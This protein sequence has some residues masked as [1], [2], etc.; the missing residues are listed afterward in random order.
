MDLKIDSSSIGRNLNGFYQFLIEKNYYQTFFGNILNSNKIED[1][2][3]Y[4]I[5]QFY[6]IDIDRLKFLSE[7]QINCLINL[8]IKR[9]LIGGI[10]KN[11][12]FII[13]TFLIKSIPYGNGELMEDEM[14]FRNW[15]TVLFEKF[16]FEENVEILNILLSIL[17]S[18][19]ESHDVNFLRTIL[20]NSDRHETGKS[21]LKKFE[22]FWIKNLNE[23]HFV[24][25]R[26]GE[27]FQM[28]TKIIYQQFEVEEMN[29]LKM[30][31]SFHLCGINLMEKKGDFEEIIK[32]HCRLPIIMNST[33][34]SNII[35]NRSIY[36]LL[37]YPIN[38]LEKW[39]KCGED[40]NVYQIIFY[41]CAVIKEI[42]V[43]ANWEM[44]IKKNDNYLYF[45]NQIKQT[46]NML[47]DN[48]FTILQSNDNPNELFVSRFLLCISQLLIK[49]PKHFMD[50]SN[51]SQYFHFIFHFI[52]KLSQNQ[53]KKFFDNLLSIDE[54]SCEEIEIQFQNYKYHILHHFSQ[55]ILFDNYSQFN[56][57]LFLRLFE[58]DKFTEK[59]K[60]IHK[61]IN[62]I[63]LKLFL[64]LKNGHQ[65]Q[66]KKII[67][68]YK[69]TFFH[70]IFEKFDK[71]YHFNIKQLTTKDLL[72]LKNILLIFSTISLANIPTNHHFHEHLPEIYRII[73]RGILSKFNDLTKIP[74]NQ[75][76]SQFLRIIIGVFPYYLYSAINFYNDIEIRQDFHEILSIC[77][78]GNRRKFLKETNPIETILCEI[79]KFSDLEIRE[80]LFLTVLN[81][82]K[83]VN[84]TSQIYGN[85]IN[86]ILINI[87]M[88]MKKDLRDRLQLNLF[89][90]M[91]EK[92]YFFNYLF[93]SLYSYYW[94]MVKLNSDIFIIS[95]RKLIEELTKILYNSG[96]LIYN[97]RENIFRI[98]FKQMNLMIE[99]K[100]NGNKCS[101]K[102]VIKMM[103]SIRS[104]LMIGK[105]VNDSSSNQ[106]LKYFLLRQSQCQNETSSVKELLN[107]FD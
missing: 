28:L 50:E 29:N 54:F 77:L 5:D 3:I 64:F 105:S 63:N 100:Q 38:I 53:K 6:L 98:F 33:Y 37:V 83:N 85:E 14:V 19:S 86:Q 21:F 27:V 62:Y 13:S 94:N 17:I 91:F 52:D 107:I 81:E 65:I 55:L 82:G 59:F 22:G 101:N 26:C 89:N 99:L 79:K 36:H 90:L 12:F 69:E 35:L 88:E 24:S 45:I 10:D 44:I 47:I 43:L 87:L 9:T 93:Y 41:Y 39:V 40:I 67:E 75:F 48:P 72:I 11:E 2:M 71:N 104:L 60:L 8:S 16:E 30:M 76:T 42:F 80:K 4:L 92:E 20:R 96:N 51:L 15:M 95:I 56:I 78:D 34:Y 66:N 57:N 32:K 18:P 102:F 73:F 61:P 23:I 31:F 7:N 1:K 68:K 97:E 25:K 49:F 70:S 58:G 46:I 106:S 84:R 74:S 103:M